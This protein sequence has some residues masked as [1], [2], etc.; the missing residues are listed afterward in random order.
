MTDQ[1]PTVTEPKS[2]GSDASS[3]IGEVREWLAKTFETAGKPVPEFEYTPRSVAHLHGLLT[4]SKA[5]DEA[6]RLVARDFRQKAS[7][8]RSQGRLFLLRVTRTPSVLISCSQ[9]VYIFMEI[10]TMVK[11]KSKH[12]SQGEYLHVIFLFEN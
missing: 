4:V 5:K 3:R 8:Y 1:N 7:E 10:S 2:G 6:A 12:R 9:R 11:V